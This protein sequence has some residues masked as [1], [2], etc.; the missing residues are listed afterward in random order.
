VAVIF[1]PVLSPQFLLWLLPV[2]AAA[3][4]LRVQNVILLAAVFLTQV[5]LDHYDELAS[6]SEGFVAP[7]AVRNALLLCYLALVVAPLLSTRGP[8]LQPA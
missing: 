2:S 1:S 6:L 5:V 4:G 8:R 7:L 3:F